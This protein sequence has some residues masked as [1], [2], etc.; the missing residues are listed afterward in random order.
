MEEHFNL[1]GMHFILSGDLVEARRR[2][3]LARKL[4]FQTKLINV[5]NLD[6]IQNNLRLDDGTNIYVLS[7]HGLDTA[8]IFVP[9]TVTP[10]EPRV[11]EETSVIYYPAFEA[12]NAD[13][14]H[15]GYVIARGGGWQSPYEF[16]SMPEIDEIDPF[17]W[18]QWFYSFDS[19]PF[20]S[21]DDF[22]E[23]NLF[24]IS[25][26]PREHRKLYEIP[27]T[28]VRNTMFHCYQEDIDLTGTGAATGVEDMY[29]CPILPPSGPGRIAGTMI[30]I[31]SSIKSLHAAR[32]MRF[33]VGE[34][35]EIGTYPEG[36]PDEWSDGNYKPMDVVY[37]WEQGT[38][39]T[40]WDGS[41]AV[42]RAGAFATIDGEESEW[43]C[44]SLKTAIEE[45]W[46]QPA[47]LSG[48]NLAWSQFW[49]FYP[50]TTT[51]DGHDSSYG[52]YL[53]S[54]SYSSVD[55]FD[56][57]GVC[58]NVSTYDSSVSINN[59][60]TDADL[61]LI[62]TTL[63]FFLPAFSETYG[64]GPNTQMVT[65][66]I[67]NK[68]TF[69]NVSGKSFEVPTTDVPKRIWPRY[70]RVGDSEFFIA[71]LQF[72]NGDEWSHRYTFVSK[73]N[74]QSFFDY[75]VTFDGA[76]HEIPGVTDGD[77]GTIYGNGKFRLV[78]EDTTKIVR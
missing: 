20:D 61:L 38:Y 64:T 24:Y 16:V 72:K 66:H 19:Q 52:P 56:H 30:G 5:N 42:P 25:D 76:W 60:S 15:I 36:Y 39:S 58:Y 73:T 17:E 21:I 46:T 23:P 9:P 13:Q 28:G 69:I 47:P 74:D 54:P 22:L 44:H 10:E 34:K 59:T 40:D 7:Q 11:R 43:S 67:K 75:E 31:R 71:S 49:D 37:D 6:I 45:I 4:M 65:T 50:L 32:T 68:T 29:F 53:Y 35:G 14:E 63:L 18:G 48:A 12:Y 41:R 62:G 55:D 1:Y 77:G 78:R 2:A 27:P 57:Y 26:I 8:K 3:F 70:Y 51:L 33:T